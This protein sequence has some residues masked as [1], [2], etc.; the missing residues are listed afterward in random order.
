MSVP[1]T[2]PMKTEV[3]MNR[4]LGLAT[5][6]VAASI[7]LVPVVAAQPATRPTATTQPA[8]QSAMGSAMNMGGQAQGQPA[9]TDKMDRMADAMTAMAQMCQTMMQREDRTLRYVVIGA[10]VVGAF[11]LI[12]LILF[13]VLEVQWIRFFGLRIKTERTRLVQGWPEGR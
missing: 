2:S 4:W 3:A 6:L 1:S 11:L 13:I 8:G 9:Q 7:V 10:C 12:A 5:A